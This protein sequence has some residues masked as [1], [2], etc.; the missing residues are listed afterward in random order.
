MDYVHSGIV[1]HAVLVAL[2]SALPQSV[3]NNLARRHDSIV[4]AVEM[5]QTILRL[6]QSLGDEEAVQSIQRIL[7]GEVSPELK[8]PHRYESHLVDIAT[9]T[10]DYINRLSA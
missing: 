7:D 9:V 2:I 1:N 4:V 10:I 5:L 6:A 3:V 8:F